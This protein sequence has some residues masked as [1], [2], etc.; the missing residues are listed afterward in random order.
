MKL[1]GRFG[2]SYQC[3]S[4]YRRAWNCFAMMQPNVG[5]TKEP[6]IGIS[7]TPP[8][9][10]SISW[11]AL[12]PPKSIFQFTAIRSSMCSLWLHIIIQD[13]PVNSFVHC[14]R[15]IPHDSNKVFPML[16]RR[17]ST[18]FSIFRVASNCMVP[19]ALNVYSSQVHSKMLMRF[20]KQQCC[21]LMKGSSHQLV[22]EASPN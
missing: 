2:T 7:D 6:W 14:N 9:H 15:V 16:H 1:D 13:L 18:H 8:D 5:P 4:P 20:L 21:N 10:K 12:S 11:G 17:E 22:N 19:S 3:R